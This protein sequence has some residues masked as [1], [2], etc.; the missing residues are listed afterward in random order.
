MTTNL[1]K[2]TEFER[3][4][5]SLLRSSTGYKNLQEQQHIRGVNV[6]MTFQKQWRPHK[7]LT[8]GVECK[9]WKSGLDRDALM[10]ICFSYKPLLENKDIDELWIVTPHPAHATV[11]EFANG[12]SNIALFHINELEQDIIDFSIYAH[13]LIRQ[14]DEE[15]LRQY[16]VQPREY[17]SSKR[18]HET[19]LSWLAKDTAVPVAI[20]AGYGVGKTSYAKYLAAE[21]ASNFLA[22]SSERIPI[23][24]PLGD[25]YTSPR[26]DGLL[27]NVLT[28]NNGVHGYNYNTFLNLHEAGR[29]VIILDGFDE[30]KY[31]MSSAEFH[32]IS[33]EIRRLVRPNSK[34]ILLGRPS[35][36][37]SGEEHELLVKGKRHSSGV[38]ISDEIGIHFLEI[39]IDFFTPTEYLEFVTKYLRTN[40]SGP[41]KDDFIAGRLKELEDA[42]ISEVLRRPVQARL[43]SQI[44]LHPNNSI[45]K[46]SKY[47]LYNLFV[48]ECLARESR[49]HARQRTSSNTLRR[50]MQD[51][52]WWLWT[53]KRTRTFTVY[54]IPNSLSSNYIQPNTDVISSL[55]E[56][57]I[58]SFTDEQSIGL[59]EE[60]DAGTFYFPHQSFTEFLI[61]D[62]VIDRRLSAA[63]FADFVKSF[64]PEIESF[65]L[66]YTKEDI[67]Y[68]LYLRLA[69]YEVHITPQIML[70]LSKSPRLRADPGAL[71]ASSSQFELQ[72]AVEFFC[73][74]E[75]EDS[76]QSVQKCLRRLSEIGASF[77]PAFFVAILW[78]SV[79]EEADTEGIILDLLGAIVGALAKV[80]GIRSDDDGE[81]SI[82]GRN[83][84]FLRK[85]LNCTTTEQDG[86]WISFGVS[87]AFVVASGL[88]WSSAASFL[89]EKQV[90]CRLRT[91]KIRLLKS[92]SELAVFDEWLFH[93]IAERRHKE[94][95]EQIADEHRDHGQASIT[96]L[97]SVLPDGK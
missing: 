7:Y 85:I 95:S 34:V 91:E 10:E 54:E 31:A 41:N 59:V 50:F 42:N 82:V 49:K 44:L 4:V 45:E 81:R 36:I 65:L 15:Q 37:L 84:E 40:Y 61:A 51:L 11:Q 74:I 80:G 96:S 67:C 23:Y 70:F 25:Y 55:R 66:A 79:K 26:L 30:M 88:D 3:R 18:I 13:Y 43:L 24:V 21:L 71:L 20:W 8:I 60:K 29:F 38:D 76:M 97:G 68:S 22:D 93:A 19:I 73:A 58:S 75:A 33:L 94:R 52:A 86:S 77:Y 63:E 69:S 28:N 53:T 83:I 89:G 9:N 32:A 64:N 17:S 56:L 39:R 27:S 16:Y 6:D 90:V 12:L 2:G 14:F 87:A 72:Y 62:Y 47:D 35:A 46:I 1:S 78:A 48:D 57:L 5:A 92:K